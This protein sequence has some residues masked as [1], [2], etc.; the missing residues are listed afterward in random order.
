MQAS[1]DNEMTDRCERGKS[2][3]SE[4]EVEISFKSQIFSIKKTALPIA[5]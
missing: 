2:Q 1:V 3:P 5:T 4:E